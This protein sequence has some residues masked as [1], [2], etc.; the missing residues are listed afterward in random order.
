MGLTQFSPALLAPGAA[1][2]FLVGLLSACTRVAHEPPLTTEPASAQTK[3]A[4]A[5]TTS[6][7]SETVSAPPSALAAR[8][9]LFTAFQ[10]LEFAA[11]NDAL[12]V[13][14]ISLKIGRGCLSHDDLLRSFETAVRARPDAGSIGAK[15]AER[16]I[17][18]RNREHIAAFLD[19]FALS[20]SE[21]TQFVTL[22][23][24][25]P[26]GVALPIRVG[27]KSEDS[28]DTVFILHGLLP[29]QTFVLQ[30][31]TTRE[32]AERMLSSVVIPDLRECYRHMRSSDFKYLSLCVVYVCQDV[33]PRALRASAS[34]SVALVSSMV[35]LKRFDA[36]EL[37]E[38]DLLAQSDV[39]Q[40]DSH[41]ELR[42]IR[43]R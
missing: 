11:G 13:Q 10:I 43:L 7:N 33:D 29:P 31:S 34:E 24:L 8:P 14:L 36:G 32:R 30:R 22:N 21:L 27:R 28:D 3:I 1:S 23:P 4:E 20:N 19:Q 17:C 37:A 15:M 2:C 18:E 42:K 39:F 25:D 26:S 16:A 38:D 35:D 5:S 40:R 6:A 12:A 41:G 9:D